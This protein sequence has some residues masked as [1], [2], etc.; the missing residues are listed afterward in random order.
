MSGCYI[1]CPVMKA[2]LPIAPLPLRYSDAGLMLDASLHHCNNNMLLLTL[3]LCLQ[4]NAVLQELSELR[5]TQLEQLQ[6]ATKKLVQRL[7]V[8]LVR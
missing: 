4:L 6:H 7:G 2:L 1:V 3:R 5:G 8:S